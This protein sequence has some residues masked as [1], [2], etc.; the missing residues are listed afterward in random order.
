MD[1]YTNSG[2]KWSEEEKSELHK[3]Y[4]IDKL[5][6]EEL[7]KKHKRFLGGITS[8]LKVEGLINENEEATGYNEFIKSK[9]Y[10]HMKQEKKSLNN[11]RIIN[12]QQKEK[13]IRTKVTESNVLLSI[14]Q[15]DYDNLIEEIYEVKNELNEIKIMIRKLAIYD[16]DD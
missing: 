7:C 5:N 6:V 12:K 10:Y 3:G 8:R 9:E 13:E 2:K 11:E 4:K 1:Y 15:S 14:K 16:F